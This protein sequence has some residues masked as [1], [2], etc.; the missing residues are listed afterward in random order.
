M[1]C[2]HCGTEIA[3]KALICY[4]CG[5]A[6]ADPQFRPPEPVRRVPWALVLGVVLLIVAVA[7]GVWLLLGSVSGTT[8]YLEPG[9]PYP[10]AGSPSPPT[11][12]SPDQPMLPLPHARAS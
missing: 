6:T 1:H 11:T 3:D 8:G 2:R 12:Q 10:F 4:R 7:V 9:S 5:A